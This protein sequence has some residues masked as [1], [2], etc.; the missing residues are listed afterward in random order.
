MFIWTLLF[1]NF[2]LGHV[3]AGKKNDNKRT[4]DEKVKLFVV[5]NVH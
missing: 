5:I 2:I 3:V 1:A 4:I